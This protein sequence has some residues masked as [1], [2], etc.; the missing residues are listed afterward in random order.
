M[1]ALVVTLL[2]SLVFALSAFATPR[3]EIG[4][5]AAVGSPASIFVGYGQAKTDPAPSRIV[6]AVPSAYAFTPHADGATPGTWIG[7]DV[8]Q[9]N[10]QIGPNLATGLL[11]MENPA[12]FGAEALVCTRRAGHDAVWAAH[13]GSA[14]GVIAIPIFVDR[15]TFTICPD[16]AKLG[17]T[18]TAL[19][20]QLGLVGNSV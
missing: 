20:L 1:K 2:A 18:P 6:I 12:A 7:T 10:P 17:G 8:V 19:S 13:I 9:L 16:A 4:E 11:T 14:S 3:L 15:R 5:G